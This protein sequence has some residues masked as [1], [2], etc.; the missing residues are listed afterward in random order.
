MLFEISK[1]QLLLSYSSLLLPS[2]WRRG[3][4]TSQSACSA[5]NSYTAK[6]SHWPAGTQV[7]NWRETRRRKNKLGEHLL[8]YQHV[9]FI[10][11]PTLSRGISHSL[12]LHLFYC[13]LFF[14]FSPL[15]FSE[16]EKWRQLPVLQAAEEYKMFHAITLCCFLNM[17]SRHQG[18]VSDKKRMW[19]SET[20]WFSH[21]PLS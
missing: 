11:I 14:C 16:K 9:I 7:G 1:H 19:P 12:L 3:L 10:A 18:Q 6:L 5:E 2:H 13:G 4:T 20:T 21:V 17:A 8:L 15:Q